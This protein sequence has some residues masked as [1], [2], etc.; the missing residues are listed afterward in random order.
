MLIGQYKHI[1]TNEFYNNFIN[2]TGSGIT[3]GLVIFTL[4]AAKFVQFKTIGKIK[5]VPV[6]IAISTYGVIY[7]GIVPTLNSVAAPW[8][9]PAIISGFLI[10]GWK[11]AV[12]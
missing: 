5:L 4:V 8:T 3:I 7:F 1:V 10:G 12:W 11:M 9:T 6:I 2:L